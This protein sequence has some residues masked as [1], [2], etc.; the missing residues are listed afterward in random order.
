M[1]FQ[2]LNSAFNWFSNYYA[3]SEIW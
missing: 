3:I 1:Q 2:I